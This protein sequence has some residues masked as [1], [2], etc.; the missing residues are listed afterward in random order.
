MPAVR[1]TGA[2]DHAMSADTAQSGSGL[3]TLYSSETSTDASDAWSQAD[4]HR[5]G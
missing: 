3:Q 4:L 1:P 2:I 5:L